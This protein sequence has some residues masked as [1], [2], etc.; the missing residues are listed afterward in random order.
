MLQCN[1]LNLLS[2]DFTWP[3]R[4]P[5][6]NPQPTSATTS[7]ACT[8]R[9]VFSI[10]TGCH[11]HPL[12]NQGRRSKHFPLARATSSACDCAGGRGY[13]SLKSSL[14]NPGCNGK[15]I[16]GMA[17]RHR[18]DCGFTGGSRPGSRRQRVFQ[19]TLKSSLN[20]PGNRRQT[21]PAMAQSQALTGLLLPLEGWIRQRAGFSADS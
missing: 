19:R 17:R 16:S 6:G 4:P 9:V 3:K 11:V 10:F 15:S 2:G 18:H 21:A 14:K 8:L 20:N 13:V 12:N 1:G 7:T 5:D